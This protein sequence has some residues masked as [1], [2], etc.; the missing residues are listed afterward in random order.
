MSLDFT[1]KV[2]IVTGAG[3]G[4][5][6]SH[7]LDFARRGAK[8]VVN[9]LGGTLDGSGGSSEAAENGGDIQFTDADYRN[10]LPARY[11]DPRSS[12]YEV[13]IEKNGPSLTINLSSDEQ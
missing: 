10:M 4:L 12:D 7:A 2:V 3:G 8:V 11:S 9:D 6:R 1:G 5:G 13:V